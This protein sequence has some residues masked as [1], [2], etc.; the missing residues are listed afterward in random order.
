MHADTM[1]QELYLHLAGSNEDHGMGWRRCG[2][3]QCRS[4][5]STCN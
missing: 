1:K 4:W 5:L 3:T 2:G